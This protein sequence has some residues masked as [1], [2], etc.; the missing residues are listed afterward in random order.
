MNEISSYRETVSAEIKELNNDIIWEKNCDFI[1]SQKPLWIS[2][3][4][5]AR[6]NNPSKPHHHIDWC[7]AWIR[8]TINTTVKFTWELIVDTIK[9]PYH[10]YQLSTGKANL[11][12]YQA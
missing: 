5:F 4:R 1:S 10:V 9:F 6:A 8:Q 3:A 7:V 11:P 12:D 2:D